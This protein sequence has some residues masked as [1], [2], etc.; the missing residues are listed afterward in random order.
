MVVPVYN[1]AQWSI[2]Q[3]ALLHLHSQESDK[4]GL[5]FLT[6]TCNL[7]LPDQRRM[8]FFTQ[9]MDLRYMRLWKDNYSYIGNK[10]AT[11][12]QNISMTNIFLL[13]LVTKPALVGQDSQEK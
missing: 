5:L 9:R 2:C 1:V 11:N 3:D 6:A 7:I 8:Y 12:F 4:L 10:L 13:W